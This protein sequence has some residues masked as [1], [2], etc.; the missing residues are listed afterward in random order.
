MKKNEEESEKDTLILFSRQK[1]KIH[2][3]R[4]QIKHKVNSASELVRV[5]IDNLLNNK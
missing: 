5:A 2:D 1:K 3:R 4:V